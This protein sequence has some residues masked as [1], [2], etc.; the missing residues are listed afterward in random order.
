M[1]NTQ[2]GEPFGPGY[3]I[4]EGHSSRNVLV[5]ARELGKPFLICKGEI[6]RNAQKGE[7]QY[8]QF[9]GPHLYDLVRP[10]FLIR[11]PIRV[12]DSWK[13]VGWTDIKSLVDCYSSMFNMMHEA[14]SSSISFVL[15]ERLVREPRT[16]INRI[17]SHWGVPFSETM[18]RFEQPFGHY[19]IF[20]NSRENSISCDERPPGLFTTV[21]ASS[22][23]KN[24]VPCHGL[25]SNEEKGILEESLGRAYLRCWRD[26]V[27]RLRDTIVEKTWFGFDLDDTLHEYRRS[28]KA[29]IDAVLHSM[30]QDYGPPIS[31]LAEEYARV[32]KDKTSSA[33]SDGRTSFEYRRERFT[34]VLDKFG[35]PTTQIGKY[36]SLYEATLKKSLQLKAGALDL[37][38]LLKKMN[39]N[40]VV[41]TEGPQDAQERAIE[42]LGIKEHV[43]F[44][45]TTNHFR[46]TKSTGLFRKVLKY[47]NIPPGDM[48]YV[49][50]SE[51]RDMIPALA[52]GIFSIHL[53][54]KNNVAL[55]SCPPRINTLR[56]LG[57]IFTS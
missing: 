12:F 8:K 43:D 23:I 18:L 27:I 17:C 48:I 34:S 24:D 6:G 40:L 7:C 54:E 56:K 28:S 13:K 2:S 21:E 32:L 51:D 9:P 35:L 20:A 31:D 15:Y 50:D 33:F 53:D 5:E 3:S 44:L 45:A 26:D 36:L 11:D 16:E 29:A 41:I 55:D 39:K 22:S 25:L 37:L 14:S 4:V 38:L 49:G 42:D 30:S 1:G 46:A 52:E 10:V 57:F 19:F 47:L